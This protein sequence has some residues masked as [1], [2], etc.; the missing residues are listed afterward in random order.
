MLKTINRNSGF[1][2]SSRQD[3]PAIQITDQIFQDLHSD[4]G[5]HFMLESL[6][7]EE[8]TS[9]YFYD[10]PALPEEDL[11]LE[12][13]TSTRSRLAAT[14][15]A[16]VRALNQSL[17]GTGITAGNDTAGEVE[18]GTKS[19]GGANIGRARKVQGVAV[20]PA[21]IPLSDGQS[22]TLIFHSPSGNVG[23]I[24]ATD[25]L[26]AFRFLLNKR[27]VTNVVSPANGR[28]ISLKQVTMA[29]SNLIERNTAKFQKAQARQAAVK[30]EIAVLQEQGD[31]LEQQLALVDSG[32][33]LKASVTSLSQQLNTLNSQ[34][35]KQ[36]DLNEDLQKQIEIAK[37]EAEA[38]KQKPV[39][40]VENEPSPFMIAAAAVAART[41]HT[42]DQVAHWADTKNISSDELSELSEKLSAHPTERNVERLKTAID[43]GEG[44]PALTETEPEPDKTPPEADA[45]AQKAIDYLKGITELDSVDL[46]EI[47]NARGAVREAIAALTAAGIYD[48]NEELVNTAVQH[49]SDLLARVAQGGAAA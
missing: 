30:N 5:E 42:E 3:L 19:I 24:T 41:G 40:P 22:I 36:E 37:S 43:F 44:I 18:D 23:T 28:D 45:Q 8:F 32:D 11:M 25:T 20:M 17:N 2:L 35:T 1:I 4:E 39:P 7:L 26:V 29:L 10:V 34:A 47:R 33:E 21:Q 12:A 6:S 15:R 48:E 9:T 38:R 27:D 49:L 46:V 16:F 31:K 14:M 13:I